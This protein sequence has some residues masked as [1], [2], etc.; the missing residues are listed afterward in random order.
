MR[1]GWTG[2][3]AFLAA[4]AIVWAATI[5]SEG[6][7]PAAGRGQ[8][9]APQT[10][11]PAAGRQAAAP[12]PAAAAAGARTEDGRPNLNGGWQAINTANWD[13]E[14]HQAE[15]GPHNNIMG[16]WGAEP[17][18]MGIVEGGAIPYKPEPRRRKQDNCKTRMRGKST[19]DPHRFDPADPEL[20]CFRPGVP[21]AN[22]MP[23]TF[24]IFQNRDHILMVYVF[25]CAM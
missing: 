9:A 4:M 14:A 15:A 5:T 16:A 2:L 22:Y 20:E 13:I 19:N 8:A 10:A 12:R 11:A 23:F 25:M 18:G 1:I 6:Q 3:S 21:R 24:Q 7:A 17:A